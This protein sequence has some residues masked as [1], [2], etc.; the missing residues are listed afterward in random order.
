MITNVKGIVREVARI[1][2]VRQNVLFGHIRTP[3]ESHARFAVM[4]LA[5]HHLGLGWSHIGR[6]LG[7]RDH[8]TIAHGY[9]RC[10][11]IMAEDSDYRA[12]VEMIGRL[13]DRP[14]PFTIA[15]ADTF[16]VAFG[17]AQL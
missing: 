7:G 10:K 15:S 11:E 14:E 13:I 2:G 12:N 3:Y 16:S 5:H 8:S 4:Y 1:F 6:R 17:P 9:G